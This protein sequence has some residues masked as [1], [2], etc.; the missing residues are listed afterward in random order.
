MEAFRLG[1]LVG[2][3]RGFFIWHCG[4]LPSSPVFGSAAGIRCGVGGGG[5]GSFGGVLTSEM[6]RV[7]S[8]ADSLTGTE[9]TPRPIFWER[10]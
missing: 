1:F 2:E 8:E 7:S 4:L 10:L 6:V 9:A 5:I 3:E